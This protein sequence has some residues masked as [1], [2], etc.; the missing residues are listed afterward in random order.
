[1]DIVEKFIHDTQSYIKLSA[2]RAAEAF[3]KFN[4]NFE[5]FEGTKMQ[6]TEEMCEKVY[7][8]LIH[9]I[10]HQ[11]ITCAARYGL[12]VIIVPVNKPNNKMALNLQL[13]VIFPD[14]DDD[15]ISR[16]PEALEEDDDGSE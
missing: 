9:D 5:F 14:H 6:L 12:L 7:K 4:V 15:M 11:Q 10:L 8:D 1:M 16:A 13:G 3:S 2:K